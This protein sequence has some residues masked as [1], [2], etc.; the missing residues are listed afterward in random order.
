MGDGDE[1][2]VVLLGVGEPGA[3]ALEPLETVLAE[4]VVPA[5]TLFVARLQR[6]GNGR[7]PA[8]GDKRA[9]F[10]QRKDCQCLPVAVR[11]CRNPIV[12]IARPQFL[13]GTEIVDCHPDVGPV[14]GD[15][16]RID[17]DWKRPQ[18][19]TITGA[20]LGDRTVHGVC[21]PDVGSIKDDSIHTAS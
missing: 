12:A 6:F 2:E 7:Q 18:V 14:V 9:G 17:S 21:H 16:S 15:P 8:G 10:L 5:H 4:Q 19:S 1:E 13:N 20:Q 3:V 11:K